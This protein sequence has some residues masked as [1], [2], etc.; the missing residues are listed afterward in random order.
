MGD[1]R[2]FIVV[3][4][5]LGVLGLAATA[6]LV[7]RLWRRR[8]T[9]SWVMKLLTAVI[10]AAAVWGALGTLQGVVRAFGAVGGESVDPSQKARILAEGISEA[11]NC[12]A[13]SL[14]IGIPSIIAAVVMTRARK[15]RQP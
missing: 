14:L 9:T 12:M 15:P 5:L 6:W 4:L 8:S 13:F 1:L 7:R 10:V 2:I 3:F 11:M